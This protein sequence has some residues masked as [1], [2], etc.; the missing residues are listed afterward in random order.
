M[1]QNTIAEAI[2]HWRQVR[3]LSQRTLA[4]R[5]VLSY[6]H[7]ARLEL[8]QGNPTVSTLETLAKALEIPVVDLLIGPKKATSKQKRG[9]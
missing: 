4:E 5:T 9:K 7:I 1:I 2:K 8:C 3:G 6:V